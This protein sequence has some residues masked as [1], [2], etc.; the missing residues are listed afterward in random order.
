M[1]ARQP[2]PPSPDYWPVQQVKTG[3]FAKLYFK[4]HIFPFLVESFY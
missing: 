4:F 3:F 2:L 1:G